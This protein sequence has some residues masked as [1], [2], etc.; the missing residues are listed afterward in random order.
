[1]MHTD[2]WYIYSK[3]FCHFPCLQW[4]D[5]QSFLGSHPL[6]AVGWGDLRLL[7]FWLAQAF[8]LKWRESTFRIVVYSLFFLYNCNYFAC[9]LLC[10]SNFFFSF[11]PFKYKNLLNIKS[12]LIVLC[13]E[14][15]FIKCKDKSKISG[16]FLFKG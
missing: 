10:K 1:M 13:S 9:I 16:V 15:L 14:D 6:L 4:P 3:C 5:F 8:S 12:I 11:K 2:A 7:I